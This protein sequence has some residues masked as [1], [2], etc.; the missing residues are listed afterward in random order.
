MAESWGAGTVFGVM[1]LADGRVYC[2]A[3]APAAPGTRHADELAE[4]ARLFGDWHDPI[5]ELLR[6]AS[7]QQ[8]LHHDVE[9]LAR[10]LPAF[11]R[12]RVALLGDAAHPMTPNLGQGGCQALEDA[13]VIARLAAA[14]EPGAIPQILPSYTTA[15]LP[16]TTDVTRRSRRV[17]AMATWTSPPAVAARNAM[18]LAIGKLMPGAALRSLAPVLGWRPPPGPTPPSS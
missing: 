15:R 3:A 11:H 12:G 8:V 1:P 18:T 14:G 9:E 6:G 13:A 17:A 7:P 2:Y 10:P 4:L 16:R 5:P